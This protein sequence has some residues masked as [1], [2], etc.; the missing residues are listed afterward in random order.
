[1]NSKLDLLSCMAF[2]ET[3][4]V[5][6]IGKTKIF[7][8]TNGSVQIY[9]TLRFPMSISH[10][11]PWNYME[12]SLLRDV[13]SSREFRGTIGV[14]WIWKA[15]EILRN[16]FWNNMEPFASSQLAVFNLDRILFI[17]FLMFSVSIFDESHIP[18]CGW[19]NCCKLRSTLH[20]SVLFHLLIFIINVCVIPHEVPP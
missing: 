13:C 17:I 2:H 4:G 11:V 5:F 20:P 15:H 9:W 6:E 1:M 8:D 14:I 12:P 16:L 19:M 7:D 10:A 18:F 3:I